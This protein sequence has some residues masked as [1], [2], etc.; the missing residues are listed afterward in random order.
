MRRTPVTLWRAHTG[1]LTIGAGDF[2]PDGG[3][4]RFVP[5]PEPATLTL[6]AAG[7]IACAAFRRRRAVYSRLVSTFEVGK[8]SSNRAEMHWGASVSGRS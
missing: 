7:G 2:V 4:F 1:E 5:I 8:Y 6:L 3:N